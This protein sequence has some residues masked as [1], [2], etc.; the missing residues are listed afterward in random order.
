MN[1]IFVPNWFQVDFRKFDNE[2]IYDVIVK[3]FKLIRFLKDKKLFSKWFFL[4]EGHTIR[5]RFETR[6]NKILK[7][8]IEDF[9]ESSKLLQTDKEWKFEKYWE[10]ESAFPNK[11][12]ALAFANVMHNISEL[13]MLKEAET[14]KYDNYRLVERISH[15]IHNAVFGTNSEEAF[16]ARRLN[17]RCGNTNTDDSLIDLYKGLWKVG[18][19]GASH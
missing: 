18:E 6:K 13:V 3:V 2:S 1:K 10:M 11:E 14:I 9:C 19:V 16:L 7:G 15:C 12:S 17:E 5:V 8:V 4:Y